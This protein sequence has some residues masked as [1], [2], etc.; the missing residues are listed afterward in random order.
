MRFRLQR[1]IALVLNTSLLAF[2]SPIAHAEDTSNPDWKTLDV[3]L[4][5]SRGIIMT[6]I[7]PGQSLHVQ[8]GVAFTP[9]S[10]IDCTDFTP[11]TAEYV[12]AL[13]RGALVVKIQVQGEKAPFYGVLALCKIHKSAQGPAARSYNVQVPTEYLD[14]ARG[15]FVSVVGEKVAVARYSWETPSHAKLKFSDLFHLQPTPA[16]SSPAGV[17]Q[18]DF[19]WIIWLTDR[20][21][22]FT[23]ATL[24]K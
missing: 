15:G 24:V 21:P 18:E 11:A 22:T 14:K 2:A 10:S 6:S 23:E 13:K 3:G 4:V 17:I 19:S 8:S 1:W 12:T 5:A 20:G 9:T 7:V 16:Q